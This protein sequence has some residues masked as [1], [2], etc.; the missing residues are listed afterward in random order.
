MLKD[1]EKT[2]L[3]NEKLFDFITEKNGVCDNVC[4]NTFCVILM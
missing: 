1:R 3:F 2:N 4:L